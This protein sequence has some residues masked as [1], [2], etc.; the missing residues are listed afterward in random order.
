M[1]DDQVLMCANDKGVHSLD[2]KTKSSS[3]QSNSVSGVKSDSL[4]VSGHL[5]ELELASG[6]VAKL[7]TKTNIVL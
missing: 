1:T 7:D 6:K 5:A 4:R 3:W 2:V